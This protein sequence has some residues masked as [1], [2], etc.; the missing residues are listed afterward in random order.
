VECFDSTSAEYGILIF[1][2]EDSNLIAEVQIFG[3][4]KNI[5]IA[6]N[7]HIIIFLMWYNVAKNSAYVVLT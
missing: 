7:F 2:L 1:D 5:D 3:K 4:P 6:V